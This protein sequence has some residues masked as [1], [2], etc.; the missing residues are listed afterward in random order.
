V[1]S[2]PTPRRLVVL[3]SG[4][5]TTMRAVLEATGNAGYG[6]RIEAV[7]SDRADA[8][9][10]DIARAAGVPVEVLPLSEFE[11]RDRWDEALGEAIDR[12]SPD[13]VLLAGF[14]KIVSPGVVERFRGRMI[15]T[16]PALLP[17]FPGAHAVRDALAH[18]VKVTGC[19]VHFVEE[20]VDSGPIIAQETVAVE[21]DDT[22]ESLHERIKSVERGLVVATVERLLREGWT[23]DGRRVRRGYTEGKES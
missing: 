23:I 2:E 21:D 5:G 22:E 20:E 16:H 6:A 13:L 17:A 1:T 12:H 18:G 15:N 14:M 10:L 19:T 8:P 9:A 3:V 7:I 11:T 4:A